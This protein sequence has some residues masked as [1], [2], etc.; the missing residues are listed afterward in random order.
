MRV[1][2][3]ATD[4]HP[5][6]GHPLPQAGEGDQAGPLHSLPGMSDEK[7]TEEQVDRTKA[8][9]GSES[10]GYEGSGREEHSGENSPV[11]NP[12]LESGLADNLP[13]DTKGVTSS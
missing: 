2:A 10:L 5:A 4:P 11:K 13:E 12:D 8:I 9:R 6:F 7:S 1:L 3:R